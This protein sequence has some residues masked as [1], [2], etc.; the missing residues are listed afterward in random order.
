MTPSNYKLEPIIVTDGCYAK[1]MA[2]CLWQT[3]ENFKFLKLCGIVH[4]VVYY[5]KIKGFVSLLM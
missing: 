2:L 1:A 4:N 5:D 3:E